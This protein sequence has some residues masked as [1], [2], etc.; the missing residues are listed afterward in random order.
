MNSLTQIRVVAA[1]RQAIAKLARA[2]VPVYRCQKQGAY[3]TFCVPD[4]LVKKVFAIFAHPCYNI[5]I[6]RKSPLWRFKNFCAQRAFLL[7]GGALFAATACLSDLFVLRID[8]TGSGAYLK[9]AVKSIVYDCGVREYSLYSGVDEAALISRVLLLP[10]V[11]F[12][13]VQK[14]GNILYIDVEVE[15]ES[16]LRAEYAPLVVDISG[17]VQSV[18]ALCGT[19]AVQPGESVSAGDILIFSYSLQ[20]GQNVPCL[21]VGYAVLSCSASVSYA[22]DCASDE[23]LSAAYAA[24]LLYVGDGQITARTHTIKTNASGVIYTVDFTYLHTLTI[25]FG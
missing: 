14:S 1:P 2:G 13:S 7:V 15:K 24:A 21:A 6:E 17:T 18:V 3:F 19:P 9:N 22:A 11:T 4:N 12:C 20:G 8:V 10:G 5:T 23:N 25:N 16:A